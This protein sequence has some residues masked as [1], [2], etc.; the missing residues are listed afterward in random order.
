MPSPIE[1]DL[2][3]EN[4][5]SGF[6]SRVVAAKPDNQRP[7]DAALPKVTWSN[8]LRPESSRIGLQLEERAKKGV[9]ADPRLSPDWRDRFEDAVWSLMNLPE[10]VW[11][12]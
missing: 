9:A 7:M 8:H 1:K 5:R 11:V 12:P 6:E 3:V 4:L 10:F 2:L